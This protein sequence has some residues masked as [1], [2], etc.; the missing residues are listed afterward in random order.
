MTPQG[1]VTA[2]HSFT[3]NDP[4]P[5][6]RLVLGVDGNFYGTTT[7]SIHGGSESGTILRITPSGT[8]TVMAVF[9]DVPGGGRPIAALLRASDLYFYG[10]TL[11]VSFSVSP[12]YVLLP[13]ESG[14]SR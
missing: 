9:P 10:T 3:V 4:A 6:A 1:A 7:F 12:G 14:G 5:S 8:L 13:D 2:L 11:K